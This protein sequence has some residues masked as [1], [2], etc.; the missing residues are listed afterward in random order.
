MNEI[1]K[2]VDNVLFFRWVYEPDEDLD[3][4]WDLYLSNHPEEK[5]TLLSLKKELQSFHI[6]FRKM[7][8]AR[9][10]ELAEKIA[11]RI[12]RRRKI[13]QVKRI[14]RSLLKYAAVAFLFSVLGGGMVS[15]YNGLKEK[16]GDKVQYFDIPGIA[17]NPI[18]LLSDGSKINLNS[19]LPEIRFIN[20]SQM[21]LNN[22]SIISIPQTSEKLNQ[23]IIPY[24]CRGRITL[25][26]R[27]VVWLNAGSRLFFPTKFSGSEREVV[28]FGEAF[29]EVEHDNQTSFRVETA[30]YHIRVLGTK[31]NVSAYPGDQLSH[32]ILTEGK[33]EL[34][35]KN[36][37]WFS[38]KIHLNPNEM[39]SYSRQTKASGVRKVHSDKYILW[40]EGIVPFEE[41]DFGA[42]IR[43]IEKYYDIQISLGNAQDKNIILSGKLNLKNDKYEVLY[44]V[45]KVANRKFI[46][47]NE[48]YFIIQ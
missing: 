19:S 18:L 1:K 10:K 38:P 45:T 29:F 28:L 39:Y 23:L 41:E 12:S 42:V 46:E 16:Q 3:A 7:P 21:V 14:G 20:G 33:V 48:R 13:G 24:G 6:E 35:V 25:S 37:G 44:Y 32:T 40:K 34:L 15:L 27:S 5:A 31:F 26:D 9:K 47:K 2:Y 11:A 30:D 8:E 36:G 43:K 22:D 17:G 4:Y